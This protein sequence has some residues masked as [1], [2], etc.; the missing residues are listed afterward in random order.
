MRTYA[1]CLCLISWSRIE[2]GPI[3][4]AAVANPA[5][6]ISFVEGATYRELL[7]YIRDV[8]AER[9][10]LP[11]DGILETVLLT[12]M[13]KCPEEKKVRL[14]LDVSLPKPDLASRVLGA[15][16]IYQ[17]LIRGGTV[18]AATRTELIEK[19]KSD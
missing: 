3:R 17:N 13:S 1:L 8:E 12:A 16:A 5:S 14:H 9:V 18:D 11:N 7:Q 10:T 15:R 19:L 2:A 4:D 6:V